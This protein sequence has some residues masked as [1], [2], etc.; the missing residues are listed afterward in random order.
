MLSQLGFLAT[1][2]KFMVDLQKKSEQI[3][4]EIHH[5]GI[6]SH[7]LLPISTVRMQCSDCGVKQT[8]SHEIGPP[9]DFMRPKAKSY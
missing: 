6:L 4:F 8:T 3:I 7:P 2:G 1:Y 5:K 9:Q